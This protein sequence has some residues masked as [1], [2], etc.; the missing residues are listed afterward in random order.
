ME[1]IAEKENQSVYLQAQTSG[2]TEIHKLSVMK[3][4]GLGVS[5]LFSKTKRRS[6][7]LGF[8]YCIS[9]Y[10]NSKKYIG[11]THYSIQKRW[12]EHKYDSS[13]SRCINRPLYNAIKKYGIDNFY[14]EQIEEVSDEKLNEREIY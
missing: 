11:Q 9:N 14:I 6:V 8:I 7:L 2:L 12:Q 3:F 10:I 5:R 4:W 13:R 1:L